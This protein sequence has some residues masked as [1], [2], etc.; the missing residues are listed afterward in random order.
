MRNEGNGHWPFPFFF[1]LFVG[2]AYYASRK[3]SDTSA[4][5]GGMIS[6]PY[7]CPGGT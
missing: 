2:E 6:L 5:T 3:P 1:T 4:A 7:E